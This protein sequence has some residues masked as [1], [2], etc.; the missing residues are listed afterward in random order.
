MSALSLWKI[1]EKKTWNF[2]RLVNESFVQSAQ[3]TSVLYCRLSRHFSVLSHEY[4][5]SCLFQTSW[6][7]K[8]LVVMKGSMLWMQ[9]QICVENKF[10]L[11]FSCFQLLFK[12]N[13]I[14]LPKLFRPT[15]KKNVLMMEKK[16]WNLRLKAENL[17]NNLFQ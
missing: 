9:S 4:K 13:Y 17:Q 12:K 10:C 8:L 7:Q 16:F 6:K 15:V 5:F 1:M 3:R 14:L 2:R 11:L